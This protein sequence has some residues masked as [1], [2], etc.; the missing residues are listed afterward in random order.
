MTADG[1]MV[2]YWHPNEGGLVRMSLETFRA[3]LFDHGYWGYPSLHM[4][5]LAALDLI[6]YVAAHLTSLEIP[7]ADIQAAEAFYREHKASFYMLARIVSWTA[8][9]ATLLLL[10]WVGT[11]IFDVPV[12]LAATLFLA[13][14]QQHVEQCH[15]GTLDTLFTLLFLPAV[16]FAYRAAQTSAWRDYLLAGVFCGLATAEKYNG[17]VVGVSIFAAFL[18]DLGRTRS[19]SSLYRFLCSAGTAIAV[20]LL[21]DFYLF[22]DPDIVISLFKRNFQSV[23]IRDGSGFHLWEGMGNN[24]YFLKA[25]G[26]K[27]VLALSLL[28][29]ILYTWKHP[30]KGFVLAS[31]PVA[32][33]LL[34]STFFVRCPY[35]LLPITPLICLFGAYGM[36]QVGRRILPCQTHRVILPVLTLLLAGSVMQES[37][38]FLHVLKEPDTRETATEWINEHIPAGSRMVVEGNWEHGPSLSEKRFTLFNRT[39]QRSYLWDSLAKCRAAGIEYFVVNQEMINNYEQLWIPSD[40]IYQELANDPQ[41][42]LI[43]TFQG[44]NYEQTFFNIPIYVYRILPAGE[45]DA[46]L[47]RWK[48][49][50]SGAG[51]QPPDTDQPFLKRESDRN[52]PMLYIPDGTF[53][54]GS[55][56]EDPLREASQKKREATYVPGFWID[57][58]PFPNRTG[59]IPRTHVDWNQARESCRALGKRLCTEQEWERACKGQENLRFPYGDSFDEEVCHIRGDFNSTVPLPAGSYSRC[60]S[61]YGVADMSG[62]VSEWTSGS[63]T[64]DEIAAYTKKHQR[65]LPGRQQTEEDTYYIIKGGDWGMDAYGTS[66]AARDFVRPPGHRKRETGFRCCMDA[67]DG[68]GQREPTPGVLE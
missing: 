3:P 5:T 65:V 27:P 58:Y 24:L 6:Y 64:H 42:Q 28:G 57:K 32:F 12:A 68:H 49:P 37:L 39:A 14:Y 10:Y 38:R 21:I 11:K 7:G 50:A 47:I 35:Y 4:Y 52:G 26:F 31:F 33:F 43:Q 56:P 51:D 15:Y 1:N 66:C 13:V 8:G 20:F 62:G 9:M 29:G 18:L 40:K 23:V 2:G 45:K 54:M 53:F 22:I 60:L 48:E 19:V 67:A 41:V 16:Y 44:I 61:G 34:M 17:F 30:G 55:A 59:V 63:W 46:P 36:W 25:F